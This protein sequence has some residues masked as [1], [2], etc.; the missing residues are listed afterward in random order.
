[1]D[2]SQAKAAKLARLGYRSLAETRSLIGGDIMDPGYAYAAADITDQYG[3]SPPSSSSTPNASSGAPASSAA[4][5]QSLSGQMLEQL[6]HVATD[7][8]ADTDT[9]KKNLD[10]LQQIKAQLDALF[11]DRELVR[12][13]MNALAP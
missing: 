7:L 4:P 9:Q 11:A 10:L 3:T 6:Q 5:S 12:Y 13:Q 2:T 1:V 8:E